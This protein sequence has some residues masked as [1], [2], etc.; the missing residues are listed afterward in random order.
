MDATLGV[1]GAGVMGRGL[2]QAAAQAGLRV[3]VWDHDPR[4][5]EALRPKLRDALRA[6]KLLGQTQ[7]PTQEVLGRVEAVDALD[8]LGAARWVVECVRE[9]AQTKRGLLARL[10]AACPQAACVASNTS[11]IPL[12]SL[13]GGLG[14]PGR[15]VGLHW[16][17]PV[18][19]SSTV[20]LVRGARSRDEALAEARALVERLK[21]QALEVEDGPGFVVNRVLMLAIREAIALVD[22]GRPPE[23]VDALMEGCLGHR[24]GP[25]ATADLIG[26]DTVLDTLKVLCEHL[27][28]RYEPP[29]SLL[30][31]VREGRLGRKAGRGFH[32]YEPA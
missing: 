4:A 12:W 27:G 13:V 20:E 6:A 19:A 17:N 16:M 23:L 25:L 18:P 26:L 2:A 24:A 28:P 22:E 15:V 11:A 30:A 14:D 21:K 31:L 8:R 1:I 32:R 5:L 3:C 10:E 9:D 7:A 29:P